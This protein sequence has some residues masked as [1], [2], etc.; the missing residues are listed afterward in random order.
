[1]SENVEYRAAKMITL[2]SL[3]QRHLIDDLAASN[4]DDNGAAVEHGE[5]FT[6]DQTVCFRDEGRRDDQYVAATKRAVQFLRTGNAI[7]K[8][9][10][11]LVHAPADPDHSHPK[12]MRAPRDFLSYGAETN[13][14]HRLAADTPWPYIL[15]QFI[16]DP[17][18]FA[19][20]CQH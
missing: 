20:R 17:A 19:L 8:R 15:R 14:G 9:W 7:H 11:G 12:R 6:A 2:E 18:A 16:L 4:I 13:N 3:N 5:P 10:F 1:M